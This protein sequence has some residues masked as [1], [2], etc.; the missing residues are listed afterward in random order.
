MSEHNLFCYDWVQIF[1]CL[2]KSYENIIN[3]TCIITLLLPNTSKC[4]IKI[5]LKAF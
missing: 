3:F 4:Y 1:L 2:R 5:H